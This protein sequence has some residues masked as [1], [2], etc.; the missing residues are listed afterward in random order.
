MVAVGAVI[1]H[2]TTGQI[3]L[4]QRA[5]SQDWHANEW[6]ILY[7]RID[8]FEDT[9]SGLR[10]EVKEEVGITDLKIGEPISTWHMFRG[11]KAA[12]NDLIGITFHCLTATTEVKLSAEHAA[13][14]WTDPAQA[15]QLVAVPGIRA[16][17]EKYLAWKKLHHGLVLPYL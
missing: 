9:Y 8:Q 16:D 12:E 15:P 1:E 6:E 7:G 10:R 5:G 3:L 2:E 17:L 11:P 4:I 13:F 14:Q